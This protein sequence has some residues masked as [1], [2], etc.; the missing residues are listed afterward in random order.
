[1]A[2]SAFNPLIINFSGLKA[3]IHTF[4]I[5]I[6]SSFFKSFDHSLIEEGEAE[7]TLTL[8]KQMSMLLLK[9]VFHGEI[10]ADCDRCAARFKYP[11]YG[12]SLLTVKFGDESSDD[13]EIIYLPYGEH[14][15]DLTQYIYEMH[16]LSVPLRIVPCETYGKEKYACDESVLEMLNKIS[17]SNQEIDPR[18]EALQNIKLKKT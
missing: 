3:G 4:D 5:R 1:L 13:D 11:I 15:I 8:E 7:I 12:E 14:E 6:D 16:S 9:F 18:W 10:I 17:V 2:S